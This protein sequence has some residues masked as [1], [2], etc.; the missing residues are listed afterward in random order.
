[1]RR[2]NLGYVKVAKVICHPDFSFAEGAKGGADVALLRLQHF[3]TP[4]DLINWVT[5]P[6]ASLTVPPGTR[7]WVT[8]WGYNGS[9]G[10]NQGDQLE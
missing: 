9:E 7:C 1:M 8:G 3:L 4:S 6:P 10:K 5:L 2:S